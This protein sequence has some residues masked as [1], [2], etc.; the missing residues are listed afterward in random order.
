MPDCWYRV[1]L[2]VRVSLTVVNVFPL[3]VLTVLET[4]WSYSE[5]GPIEMPPM[6]VFENEI[7]NPNPKSKTKSKITKKKHVFGFYRT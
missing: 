3:V 5:L 4:V 6:Y 2:R 1:L 7:E